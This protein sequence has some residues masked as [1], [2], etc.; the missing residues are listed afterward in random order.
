M[1]EINDLIGSVARLTSG[2]SAINVEVSI[3]PR[4]IMLLCVGILAAGAIC[5][6]LSKSL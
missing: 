2:E 1:N 6:T 5:I 4:S 3:E